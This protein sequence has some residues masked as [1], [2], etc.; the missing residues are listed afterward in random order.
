MWDVHPLGI[1]WREIWHENPIF[2]CEDYG[3]NNPMNVSMCDSFWATLG[4]PSLEVPV[5]QSFHKIGHDT[6][7]YT[8][9]VLHPLRRPS[10]CSSK[11][12]LGVWW[13]MHPGSESTGFPK[14]FLGKFTPEKPPKK[15][16]ESNSLTAKIGSV[17]SQKMGFRC[18]KKGRQHAV[19]GAV[20][21]DFGVSGRTRFH[22]ENS[23]TR[24]MEVSLV[25]TR[26]IEDDRGTG[27]W[28]GTMEFYDF[29]FSWECHHP[30]WL[31]YF[32]EGWNHQPGY[33]W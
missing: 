10:S 7:R 33:V 14:E 27:W 2:C 13:A 1:G 17:D 15:R 30:N 31:S 20:F 5:C 29:P 19:F 25:K 28:F 12:L 21:F 18:G 9:Q 16:T 8:T 11:V 24:L 23:Q 3:Q 6:P 26:L 32:S 22:E 4:F